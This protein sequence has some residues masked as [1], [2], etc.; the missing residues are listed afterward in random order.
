MLSPLQI[1]TPTFGLLPFNL[2]TTSPGDNSTVLTP[3]MFESKSKSVSNKYF[4]FKY[5]DNSSK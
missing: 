1:P 4:S 2:D 3:E 5:R